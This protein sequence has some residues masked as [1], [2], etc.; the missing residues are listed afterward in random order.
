MYS[1]SQGCI[2]CMSFEVPFDKDTD[3]IKQ[4]NDKEEFEE[5]KADDSDEFS[6][7]QYTICI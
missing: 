3:D 1:K 7:M 6:A 2:T 4:F 5:F